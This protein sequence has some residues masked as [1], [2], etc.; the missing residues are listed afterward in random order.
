MY[1]TDLA[2]IHDAGFS[3]F[4]AR[5]VLELVNIFS[6]NGIRRG[7]IV[8]VGCGSGVLA[9]GLIEAGYDVVG[10]DVS[11]EM[12]RLA[13][14]R[15]PHAA[16][17]VGSVTTFRCPRCVAVVAL[18]EVVN[19]VP[20]RL[21]ALRRFF[22]RAHDALLPGGLVI[23]DFIASAERRTYA[24]KSRSGSDWAVA[25]RAE[26]DR[27]GRV[28]TRH[29]TTFR[30]VSGEYRKSIETHRVHIYDPTE[31]RRVLTTIGF[32]VTMRRSYGRLRLLPGDVA[33][34]GEKRVDAF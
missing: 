3:D 2:Y 29:I 21:R 16:F 25:V 24:G 30:K 27:S 13:R 9:K 33:A 22:A 26:I 5:A 23:F 34:I 4:A 18:N 1:S 28:L 19:Y 10:V 20:G 32:R 7:L 11:P 6:R 31:V 12:I 8:D 15:V 14:A 17:R